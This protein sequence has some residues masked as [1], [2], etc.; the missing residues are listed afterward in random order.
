MVSICRRWARA[1][2]EQP[3]SR[4]PQGG[5]EFSGKRQGHIYVQQ[6][7]VPELKI[8]DIVILN[9]LGFHKDQEIRV[10]VRKVSARLFSLPKYP[11]RKA[12]RQDQALVDWLTGYVRHRPDHW[13]WLKRCR[14]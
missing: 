3:T 13:P 9:N 7:L 14:G 5:A 10:A 6:V 11:D 8:G 4:G 12:L 1:L 2:P